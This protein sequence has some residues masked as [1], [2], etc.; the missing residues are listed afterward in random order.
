MEGSNEIGMDEWR[1]REKCKRR[2]RESKRSRRSE[3][4]VKR[5]RRA[6]VKE[7]ER[8]YVKFVKRREKGEEREI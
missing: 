4:N 7:R 1:V 5:Q 2:T 6:T 3:K 8:V